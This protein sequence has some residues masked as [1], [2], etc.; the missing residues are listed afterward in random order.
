MLF[1]EPLFLT[2]FPAVYAFYLLV[3]GASAKKWTLLVVSTLFYVWGEPVFVLVMLVSTA[4]DYALSFYL[5]DPTPTRT[6]RLALTAGIVNNLG[7]LIVYKYADFL[8][9]NFNFVLGHFAA[10]RI[11]LLHLALPIGVSFV[12]FE[13]ITYLVDTYR[14][15]SK[16]AASFTD[17]CLFVLFF[18][19]LLAGPILKYHEMKDQ[20]AS[21]PAVEWSDFQVGFLRF[22][23]GLGRKLLI[24]DPLGAFVNQIFAADPASLSA[25]HAWLGLASFTL[26][27]YFDFAGYS[28]MAIGLARMLGFRLKENFN[29]PYI[30]QSITEFWRR[31]HISL[32]TWIR[33]YLY[34]PLGGDRSSDTRTYINLWICFLASGLWHGA[35]WNFVLWGAYNGL[36]LTLDRLFLRD[37]LARCGRGIA[38][39]ITLFIVMIGWAIFRSESPTHLVPFLKALAGLSQASTTME[40]PA[41]VPFTLILGAF[42]S[43]LPATRLYGPLTHAYEAQSWL[44]GVTISALVIIY[45]LAIARAVTVPFQP[46]IY[47]RF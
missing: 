24:A 4:I 39:A 33:D 2:I 34:I 7:I 10:N 26:Q 5:S 46:F 12:V 21:P 35:S 31:W 41:E 23:R 18:P 27:I 9:D 17:Y 47:F 29:S 32:T 8:A 6:R 42:I 14:G 20:I 11:P 37:A 30:S 36:F 43:L 16:P 1:Y 13:K 25:G 28:D 38:T 3:S 44:R 40:I 15:I 19:K 45:V 22:A